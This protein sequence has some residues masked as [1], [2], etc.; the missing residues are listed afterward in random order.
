VAEV[1]KDFG[2]AG[3][4]VTG[5]RGKVP[6]VGWFYIPVGDPTSI[7]RTFGGMR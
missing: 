3:E 1:V 6:C 2:F 4:R 7:L 5:A